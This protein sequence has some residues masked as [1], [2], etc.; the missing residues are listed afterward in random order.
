MDHQIIKDAFRCIACGKSY[1]GF[2]PR[3]VICKEFVC[4]EDVVLNEGSRSVC[5]RCFG[6]NAVDIMTAIEKEITDE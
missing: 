6:K 1:N 2:P 4:I 3:C 5:N